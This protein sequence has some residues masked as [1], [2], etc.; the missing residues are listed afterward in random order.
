MKEKQ[1]I[2]VKEAFQYAYKYFK[3]LVGGS[4][5]SIEEAEMD[6]TGEHWLITIGFDTD[7]PAGTL[8]YGKRAFKIFK[9]DAY[10]GQVISMKIRK[11]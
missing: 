2:S 11:I 8:V 4:Y 9:I 6:E 7:V 10:T 1:K 5:I 3:N